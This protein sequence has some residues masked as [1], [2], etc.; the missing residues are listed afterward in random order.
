ME[1]GHDLKK[2]QRILG[3]L[4]CRSEQPVN[5]QAR[6]CSGF[7]TRTVPKEYFWDGRRRASD[8]RHPFVIWQYTL[9]GEGAFQAGGSS[10]PV[11]VLPGRAFT[12]VVP[13]DDLYYLPPT[14]CS[15]T[16]FWLI[17]DHPYV[18]QRIH[19][20]QQTM[21]PLWEL[22][23]TSALVGRAL[24]LFDAVRA[25]SLPDE[26][27]EEAQLFQFLVEYERTAR[28][29]TYPSTEREQLLR[30]VR[31]EVL[32]RLRSGPPGVAEIAA[33]RG[34]SRTRFSH[35]FRERTGLGPGAFINQVR[36]GEAARLLVSSNLKLAAIAGL[37]GFADATHLGKVFRKHFYLTP[38]KY[39]QAMR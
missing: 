11:A 7:E 36:I 33:S 2:L 26:F 19:A 28:N 17:T 4:R 13:G 9:A 34:M 16:F 6:V 8:A 10:Q 37:A 22:A 12:T 25:A 14:S 31:A 30:E 3:A 38:D 29:L 20:R 35:Y 23:P 27:A 18:V 21:A 15:W 5:Y 32:A 24:D 1:A 39:R